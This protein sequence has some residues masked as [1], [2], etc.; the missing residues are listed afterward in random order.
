MLVVISSGYIL[1]TY[2]NYSIAGKCT[3]AEIEMILIQYPL[4]SKHLRPLAHFQG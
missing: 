1:G 4:S 2:L 3:R